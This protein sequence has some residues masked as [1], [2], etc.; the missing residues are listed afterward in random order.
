[1][2]R[3]VPFASHEAGFSL[4]EILV[5]VFIF[6][7]IGTISVALMASSVSARDINGEVLDRTAM[8]DRVR[9]LLR[10]DLGQ[11]ARRPVRDAAGYRDPYI[12]AGS[13]TGLA[14]YETGPDERVL[15]TFTRHGRANP[16]LIRPRSSLLHVTYLVHDATL[17]RRVRDYPDPGETTRITDQVLLEGVEDIEIDF[18]VG[19]AWQNRTFLSAEGQ[20][21]LPSAIRLRYDLP[22]LGEMEHVVL[23]PEA[24]R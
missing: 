5:S 2:T 6:A 9:T 7:V 21:T 20:G 1:M 14:D 17:V 12:F 11:I 15:V 3:S 18:L 13:E 8:L 16:G 10:E 24:G 19:S 4:I 22:P 23:T